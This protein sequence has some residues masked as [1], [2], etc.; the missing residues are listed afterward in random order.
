MCHI[1]MMMVPVRT[2]QQRKQVHWSC[3]F[4]IASHLPHASLSRP[5]PSMVLLLLLSSP[6]PPPTPSCSTTKIVYTAHLNDPKMCNSDKA[7]LWQNE[8]LCIKFQPTNPK[9]TDHAPVLPTKPFL[10]IWSKTIAW[11]SL[12]P[13]TWAWHP[14]FP[15]SLKGSVLPVWGSCVSE[16]E[17]VAFPGAASLCKNYFSMYGAHMNEEER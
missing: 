13:P 5:L 9:P 1:P 8:C 17:A 15:L 10:N 4:L 12:T 3:C 6:P 2:W 7:S 14:L 16:V 11:N